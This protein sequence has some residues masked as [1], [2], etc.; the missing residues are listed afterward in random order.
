MIR[1]DIFQ[2]VILPVYN[3]EKW[4]DETL[5]SVLQQSFEGQFEL[6]IYNDASTVSIQTNSQRWA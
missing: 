5:H 4:L 6:S 3:A 1:I 2:S